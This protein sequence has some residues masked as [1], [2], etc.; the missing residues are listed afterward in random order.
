KHLS[1]SERDRIAVWR[2]QGQS[3]RH[4]AKRL[5]RSPAT[6]SRELRRNSAP[7]YRNCYLAQ[8]A[9]SRADRRWRIQHRKERLKSVALRSYVRQR[10]KAGWSPELIAGRL[11]RQA[12]Y[13]RISHEAIY[14]WIYRE[15]RELIGTLARSHRRRLRRGY[16]RK[17]RKQHIPQR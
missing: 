4:M 10:L 17:H 8:R 15:A 11:S 3:L 16:S 12:R 14:Q 9:Q 6:L 7:L 13:P 5:G 1:Q 2:G